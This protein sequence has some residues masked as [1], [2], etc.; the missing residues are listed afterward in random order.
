MS[1]IMKRSTNYSQTLVKEKKDTQCEINKITKFI[2]E[3]KIQKQ[4]LFESIMND[5]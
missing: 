1:S 3:L 5:K 4:S 2:N